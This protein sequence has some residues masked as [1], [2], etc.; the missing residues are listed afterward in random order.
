MRIK[1]Y[2][3]DNVAEAMGKIKRELGPDAV[4][5]HTRKF[6]EGGFWGFFGKTRIE[7]TAAIEDSIPSSKK[8]EPIKK[9]EPPMPA[10]EAK[11]QVEFAQIY[12]VL[13]ELKSDLVKQEEQ[14]KF[15]KPLNN[16]LKDLVGKGISQELAETLIQEVRQE[17]PMNKW[18]E[19]E[20]V[21]NVLK[22]RIVH[23]CRNTQGIVLD[24]R[25]VIVALIGPTGV[26]KTTTIGK[27]AADYSLFQ[28]KSVALLTADTYRV[29]AAEQLKIF[30]DIIGNPVEIVTNPENF[31][32][33]MV[34]H[35]DK[36][37]IFIDTSGRSPHHEIHMSE[38]ENFLSWVKPDLTMLVLSATTNL[39]DQ[40]IIFERFK[41]M[42]THLVLTK[43]DESL[44]NGSILDVVVKTGLP[45]AYLTNG[46]S[47]PDN[48][49][50]ATPE[51][52]AGY[53]L[54]EN[55]N[56]EWTDKRFAAI[57]K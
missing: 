22:E 6:K 3:G 57:G 29:A 5:L 39:A 26:G 4:I 50:A 17:L 20:A 21:R 33:A 56:Y 36:E 10:M 37:L 41:K 31:S 40:L 44:H 9:A 7:I 34:K 55:C 54:G 14:E 27:L 49:E 42:S 45:V 12:K 47:V 2:V 46:Q 13:T 24:K 8:E 32:K 30:G 43:L 11:T 52:M 28:K 48:I 23:F 15:P 51:K 1:R 19:S 38:L 53:I 25:P 18:D 35:K 16:W